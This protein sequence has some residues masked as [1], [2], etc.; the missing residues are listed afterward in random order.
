MG[1]KHID[2]ELYSHYK[3]NEKGIVI[4]SKTKKKLK[5][6]DCKGYKYVELHATINGKRIRKVVYIHRLVVE[7]HKPEEYS[8]DL[9]IHHGNTHI[10]DN[11][12]TN[13]S[14]I[15]QKENL[16]QRKNGR[17]YDGYHKRMKKNMEIIQ[18]NSKPITMTMTN[19]CF[20]KR[21]EDCSGIGCDCF[22]HPFSNYR[23]QGE[24][25]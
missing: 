8:A 5:W 14:A 2:H 16:K 3:I 23:N 4:N 22:C 21:H 20:E 1:Y 19:A 9:Q 15:T 24:N 25:K 6:M 17:F 10:D 13:L 18:Q 11:D 7:I 12:V